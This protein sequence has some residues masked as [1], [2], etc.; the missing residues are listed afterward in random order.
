MNI[1]L[2]IICGAVF[3]IIDVLLMIPLS[4]ED[5]TAA[6]SAAFISRFAI[7]FLTATTRLPLPGWAS[8]LLI[9]LLISLPDAII[10]KAY[11][12]ILIS[13][14]I[15]GVIVGLVVGKWGKRQ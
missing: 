5:K 7:G 11:L 6:M 12:P 2:G 9:G 14:A 1:S 4:F 15:G 8:G 3:A 10:T 13:G